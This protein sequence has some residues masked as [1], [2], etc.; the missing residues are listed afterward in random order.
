M[1]YKGWLR[2]KSINAYLPLEALQQ[3][4][5]LLAQI[6]EPEGWVRKQPFE[7]ER[8]GRHSLR[9][10]KKSFEFSDDHYIKQSRSLSCPVPSFIRHNTK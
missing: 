7:K 6:L 3:W 9:P 10:P 4:R 2:I 1:S 5:Y 8:E